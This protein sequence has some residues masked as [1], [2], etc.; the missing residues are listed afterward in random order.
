MAEY[1]SASSLRRRTKMED[2]IGYI[3]INFR[4]PICDEG[5]ATV[6]EGF[7]HLNSKHPAGEKK[8]DCFD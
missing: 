2:N 6:W 8:V 5:F 3:A 1:A 4:C 7:G